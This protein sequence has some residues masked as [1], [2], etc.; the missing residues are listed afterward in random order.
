M[1]P[2]DG[3]GQHFKD[4]LSDRLVTFLG[5]FVQQALQIAVQ[6]LCCA[7]VATRTLRAHHHKRVLASICEWLGTFGAKKV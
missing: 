7:R 3:E 5:Q 1:L 4:Y 2:P 6:R